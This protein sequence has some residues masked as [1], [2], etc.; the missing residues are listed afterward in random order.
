LLAG[1]SAKAAF[2][3]LSPTKLAKVNSKRLFIFSSPFSKKDVF[4]MTLNPTRYR[5]LCA[6]AAGG[7][8]GWLEAAHRI[9]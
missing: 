2:M 4:M 5:H 3:P 1:V 7:F 6:N 9:S 8:H